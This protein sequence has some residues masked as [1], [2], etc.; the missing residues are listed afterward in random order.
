MRYA[1]S[2]MIVAPQPEP[3]E[4]GADVLREGGNAV[5]AGI[6]C[7][8]VQGV[9]DPLMC[10][11]AGFGSCGI[12][13]PGKKFHGYIDAHAPAPLASRPDMWANLIESEARDGYGFILKGRINDIG[14]KSICA[15]AN[16]KMYYDAH[17]EHGSLPWSRIVEPAI[18]WA[19]NGWTVRPHVHYWWSDDGAFGRA[20]NHE[21]TNFTPAARALYCRPDG[22]PK[23]VGDGVVNRDYGQTLRAIAKGGA[24]VFYSGEIAHAVAEDMNKNEALLTLDD[25]EQWRT[26][27]NAPLWGDYR[28]WR[29]SSNRPPGGGVML[30]QM[31]NILENFDLGAMEHNSAEYVR[32]VSEA[33]KRATIDKDAHVGDP[34][35][36]DVPLERLTSKAYAKEMAAEIERGVKA[37]VTRFNSGAVSKDTTHISVIDKDGNCFTM[38]HSL[39]MPSGVVTPGLG[40]MYNGCMGVFDPRPGRAGSI[41]PGKARFSSVVPSIVFKGDK[42]ELIIGAPGATQIAMGVLHATLN[43]LDFDMSMVEA[44]S[45][46]RFS[47]TSDAIDI[48]NRIQYRV[49]RELQGQGYDVVRSPYGFGFAAVHGIRVHKDGL[50]GG[51]DPGHDG[52]VIAV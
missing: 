4:A 27:R 40:F 36:V 51:A 14:Y 38:T 25:L 44:V 5:D 24:D 10:G 48:S 47:A 19:E 45:A 46:P 39:G 49:E 17:K 9:V 43:A 37:Q 12:Y 30:I 13:M 2:A 26:V 18:H 33:M 42:P 29:I 8:L 41:A 28:G 1:K 16:L 50:D 34:K 3:T 23:R 7:A 31:L 32:I 11:I 22:T 35:F 6:A 15:P 52:V 21:R 20:P